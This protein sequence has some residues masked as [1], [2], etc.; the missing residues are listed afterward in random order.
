MSET[1]RRS[2]LE[3]LENTHQD[4]VEKKLLIGGYAGWREGVARGWLEQRKARKMN[5][6]TW[7][8]I[9]VGSGM[10][11]VTSFAAIAAFAPK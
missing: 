11:I 6:Q 1:A 4:Y 7:I 8:N 2:F 10:L 3:D 9:A 5:L